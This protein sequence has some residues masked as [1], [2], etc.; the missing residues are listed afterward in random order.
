MSVIAPEIPGARVVDLFSGSGALGLEAL[1]RG[2]E[3]VTFVERAGSARRILGANIATLGA[4]SEVEVVSDDVFRFLRRSVGAGW[5][6]A[7]ADP[8]YGGDLAARLVE[9]FREEPFAGI[10]CVEHR[11]DDTLELPDHA[12]QRRYGDTALTFL[13]ADR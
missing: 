3:H 11:H 12:D 13:H 1:S 10:L 5:D 6:I 8:P 7:L 2:A 4:G 9:M